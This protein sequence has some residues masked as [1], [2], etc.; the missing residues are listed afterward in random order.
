MQRWYLPGSI[1]TQGL[2]IVGITQRFK[3]KSGPLESLL[4]YIVSFLEASSMKVL[5]LSKYTCMLH[6]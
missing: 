1:E 3:L 2:V 5:I 4:D 6:H